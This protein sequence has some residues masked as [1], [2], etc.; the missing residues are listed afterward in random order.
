MVEVAE[1]AKPIEQEMLERLANI[2][3][4]YG[5]RYLAGEDLPVAGTSH[6]NWVVKLLVREFRALNPDCVEVGG[7]AASDE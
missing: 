4:F 6:W 7:D 3:R 5:M 1:Q 2:Y